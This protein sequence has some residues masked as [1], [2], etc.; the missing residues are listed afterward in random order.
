ML[1]DQA[2]VRVNRVFSLI[3][4]GLRKCPAG[5]SGAHATGGGGGGGIG[6]KKHTR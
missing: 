3:A 4:T 2:N 1:V 5:G 6:E